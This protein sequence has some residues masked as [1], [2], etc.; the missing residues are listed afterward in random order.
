M[1]MACRTSASASWWSWLCADS[2]SA[3]LSATSGAAGMRTAFLR[4]I[5]STSATVRRCWV[6][7]CNPLYGT[8]VTHTAHSQTEAH[9]TSKAQTYF[10][11]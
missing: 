9:D 1:V 3:R 7:S 11:M 2:S 4:S 6:L 8:Q 5:C 10:Q